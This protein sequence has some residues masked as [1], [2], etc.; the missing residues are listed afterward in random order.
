[1]IVN[2]RILAV[3]MLV[4]VVASMQGQIAR[5]ALH[6]NYDRVEQLDNGLFKVL[7]GRKY[8]LMARDDK[9]VLPIKYDSIADFRN[10]YA[11][12]IN[13]EMN[14]VEGF[15]NEEGKF[16]NLAGKHFRITNDYPYFS[17][18][19]LLV[20]RDGDYY[21]INTKGEV[22]RPYAYAQPFFYGRATVKMYK[23]LMKKGNNV[24]WAYLNSEN[25]DVLPM[26]NV[27]YSDVDFLS[28]VSKGTAVIVFKKKFY[29]LDTNTGNITLLYTDA[30]HVKK[31]I[32]Q[33]TG[34]SD[35]VNY[36]D[37]YMVSA[38]NAQYQFDRYMRL[39]ESSTKAGKRRHEIDV[40]E[41]PVY[42]SDFEV[43]QDRNRNLF[44]LRYN[45]KEIL[46]P[47]FQNVVAV[48]N[49]EAVV[50][51][52][53]KYGVVVLEKRDNFS[54]RLNDNK[55]IGFLHDT[56]DAKLVMM[57]PSYIKS[58]LAS[59]ESRSADCE[60]KADERRDVENAEISSISYM[61]TLIIPD[62]I[63]E[64]EQTFSYRFSVKY[65]GLRSRNYEVNCDE[66]Y[67]KNFMVKDVKTK[68]G[69]NECHVEFTVEE[70]R[71]VTDGIYPRKVTVG[72]ESPYYCPTTPEKLTDNRYTVTIT[73][74][75]PGTI[76]FKVTIQEGNCPE[77]DWDINI[78]ATRKETKVVNTPTGDSKGKV[79][80][81]RQTVRKYVVTPT[82]PQ[83][84]KEQRVKT[85][86]GK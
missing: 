82:P 75:E 32:V 37:G 64:D 54:F 38:K 56:F 58:S 66:W 70:D 6:P 19:Y 12:I 47:Q 10:G 25:G 49:D 39:R 31:S 83:P 60:I 7:Q 59:V 78:D 20:Y 13:T 74:I 24:S 57:M 18:G 80:T 43:I 4:M 48:K 86:F 8:G 46:P 35:Y 52:E 55:K 73:N 11:V 44:G 34:N 2:R 63:S 21:Y 61:C 50:K 81:K 33:G 9:E 84:T 79:R 29:E 15:C 67:V 85:T 41:K 14:D 16:V 71:A 53:Y 3:I 30:N 76:P 36:K 69:K 27:D 68:L 65:D 26:R 45:S 72:T 28:S 77:I 42:D 40:V 1:M 5:W 17:S 22:S 51:S 23:D 62:S